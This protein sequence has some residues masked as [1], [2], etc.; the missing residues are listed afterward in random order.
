MLESAGPLEGEGHGRTRVGLLEGNRG[1]QAMDD[2]AAVTDLVRAVFEAGAAKDFQRLLRFHANDE[3]FSRWSSTPG[4]AL[5]DIAAATQEE[6]ALFGSRPEG[7][8]VTPE[9]IRVDS[10]GPVAVSTFSLH[11]RA[12]D[13]S[14]LRRTRG[15]LIWHRRA[16]GWRIV[17]EHFSP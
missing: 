7:T 15:T 14:T 2:A 11:A 3:T 13:G 8:E 10:F 9:D 16:E 1:G 6:E 4:G 12:V 17:H 5:L